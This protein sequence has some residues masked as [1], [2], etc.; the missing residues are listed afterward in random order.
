M[1]VKTKEDSPIKVVIKKP[2]KIIIITLPLLDEPSTSG[3]MILFANSRG[4]QIV[5]NVKV[6]AKDYPFKVSVNA[7]YPNPDYV[8]PEK[9]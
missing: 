1:S 2:E 3:K 7:G 6:K 5:G 9:K 4:F 8:K